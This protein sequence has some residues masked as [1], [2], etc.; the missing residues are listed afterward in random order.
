M[1]RELG[2]KLGVREIRGNSYY[3]VNANF[4][5]NGHPQFLMDKV[6]CHGNETSLQECAFS[7]WGVH[8]CSDEEIVGVVCKIPVMKCPD[9]YWLCD[10]SQ[11]CIPTGFLCDG[12]SDCADESDES[13]TH[14]DAQIEY[15]LVDGVPD[16]EGRLEIKYRGTWGTVC[17]DD[18]GQKEIEVL[19]K[20]LGHNGD[21]VG[22]NLFSF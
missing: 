4:T 15:R 20:S 14:C 3:S 9:T 7:G 21:G 22:F 16:V 17:D 6:D 8:N 10:T 18:F 5:N 19:C 13:L 1:C 2:F 11:E 12:V